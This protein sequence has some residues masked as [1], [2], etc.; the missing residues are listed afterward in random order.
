M[1]K[2]GLIGA[3]YWGKILKSKIS[4]LSNLEFIQNS[5]N[6][7]ADDFN[8]VDWIFIATPPN[9]HYKIAKDCIEKKI[10][11][12]IEKPFCSNSIEA[13]ELVFLAN[14][15]KVKIYVDN[16]FLYRSEVS[17][18]Y[19]K[20]KFIKI[21]KIVF[22]WFKY[23]PFH[24]TIANDLLYHDLYLLINICTLKKISQIKIHK[25]TQNNLVMDFNYDDTIIC[26]NYDRA[27]LFEP[28]KLILINDEPVYFDY[29]NQD[30]LMKVVEKCLN[31]DANFEENQRLFLNQ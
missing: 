19:L 12:F 28:Q 18:L 10:N 2:S 4:I 8:K 23:G 21:E 15:N 3:G 16:V 22:F 13:E 9:T 14:K 5:K 26:I 31:S 24:D 30:P 1:I 7:S 29:L 25:N 17:N 6:Y 11:V 20:Y 27:Y